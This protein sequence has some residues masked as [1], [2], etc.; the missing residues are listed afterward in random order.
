MWHQLNLFESEPQIQLCYNPRRKGSWLVTWKGGQAHVELPLIFRFAPSEIDNALMQWVTLSQNKRRAKN[1]LLLKQWE[2]IIFGYLRSPHLA[3]DKKHLEEEWRLF[4][5]K[6]AQSARIRKNRYKPRG[7]HQDLTPV[8]SWINEMFFN[9]KLEAQLTWTRGWSGTSYHTQRKDEKGKLYDLIC[10]SR[11]YDQPDMTKEIL[12]GVV[13]H[14]CLHIVI[15]PKIAEGRRFIHTPEFKKAEKL[16]PWYKDW[17][18]WHKNVLP[19]K[20]RNQKR[21]PLK[22]KSWLSLKIKSLF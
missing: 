6:Q 4:N 8:F 11:G 15:P 17:V 18:D 13:Y 2:S 1:K 21:K 9:S 12:G 10:I 5:L 22:T 16:Y 7:N 3:I 14:E 19:V 20:L